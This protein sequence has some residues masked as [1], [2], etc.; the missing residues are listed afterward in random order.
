M[1]AIVAFLIIKVKDENAA[2]VGADLSAR[3]G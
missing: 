1:V 3:C 2:D